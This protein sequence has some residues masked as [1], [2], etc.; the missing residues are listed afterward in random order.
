MAATASSSIVALVFPTAKYT[1][2]PADYGTYSSVSHLPPMCAPGTRSL[3]GRR[4][5]GRGRLAAPRR[6]RV[7]G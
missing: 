6:A 5:D 3:L 2:S 7:G 1:V 4:G